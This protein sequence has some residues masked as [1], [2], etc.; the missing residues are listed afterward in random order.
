[1]IIKNISHPSEE[2]LIFEAN[3]SML[4]NN[5]T[6]FSPPNFRD[7]N[8]F[9]YEA[10]R[11]L[12]YFNNKNKEVIHDI[13]DDLIFC[14]IGP[15]DIPYYWDMQSGLL[16]KKYD[17]QFYI[18]PGAMYSKEY[19]IIDTFYLR[20]YIKNKDLRNMI[21]FYS[22]NEVDEITS[23]SYLGY[24]VKSIFKEPI[25]EYYV[26]DKN[27]LYELVNELNSS[28]SENKFFKKMWYRGPTKEFFCE[29]D[30]EYSKAL[31]I[32]NEYC[33][34]P[35]LV[36]S[37]K[38]H[39]N[40][41]E[42]YFFNCSESLR[43]IAALRFWIL[44]QNKNLV[45]TFPFLKND[46]LDLLKEYNPIKI[47]EYCL[48]DYALDDVWENLVQ[49][50]YDRTTVLV[51]QQYGGYSSMLDITDDLEN[52]LFFAQS[53]LDTKS[54]KYKIIEPTKDRILYLFGQCRNTSTY[55]IS[56]D[57]FDYY[58]I[59]WECKVPQRIKNQKCGL[60]YGANNYAFN[61]YAYRILAKIH[62]GSDNIYTNRTVDEMFPNHESDDLYNLLLKV[63]PKLNGLYG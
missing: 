3:I 30:I 38:R 8:K 58:P 18:A 46:L 16:F 61:A 29:R 1:M 51:P 35:S 43:W 52:A 44:L 9:Y 7:V 26:T 15:K 41:K 59:D 55:N 36:P 62:L 60:L 33:K 20:Q 14:G 50:P 57:L 47:S 24:D 45:N 22:G 17:N 28:L 31:D 56:D 23:L 42:D 19:D 37:L 40:S 4:V 12:L 11:P 34:M 25:I 48:N 54:M 21:L 13:C 5:Q 53:C 39:I 49:I 32:P 63:N 2:E 10:K 27:E 6:E